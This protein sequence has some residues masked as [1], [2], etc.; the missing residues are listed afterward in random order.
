MQVVEWDINGMD[1]KVW[2]TAEKL[3]GEGEKN[4][5]LRYNS[6][7]AIKRL[8]YL[9]FSDSIPSIR[10]LYTH[11]SI[12]PQSFEARG[13]IRS[14]GLWSVSNAN[15]WS[16]T[17]SNGTHFLIKSSRGLAIDATSGMDFA[18]H[19]TNPINDRASLASSGGRC[20]F[21]F[22]WTNAIAWKFMTEK[23]EHWQSKSTLVSI[24][25]HPNFT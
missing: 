25:S 8:G 11:L 18:K 24:H 21:A 3:E 7:S 4:L 20:N 5:A 2:S 14:N 9:S 6:S 17:H 19:W 12:R 13:W 23:L 15:S 10:A 16:D 22:T 1:G